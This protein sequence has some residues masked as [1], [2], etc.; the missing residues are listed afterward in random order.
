MNLGLIAFTVLSSPLFQ[1][2][3]AEVDSYLDTLGREQDR[4]PRRLERIALEALGTPY[5]DG[6]LGEG[7]EGTYDKD[8]LMDLSRADCVTFVEQSVAL[9]AAKSYQEAFDGL[10]HIRYK[11]GKIDFEMRNHFMISDWIANNPWCRDIS[12][13]LGVE[14]VTSTRVISKRDF[15]VRVKAPGLGEEEQDRTV[16]IQYVPSASG[17]EAAVKLPSPALI[18]FIGKVDWLFA[19]HCGLFIRDE[20][21]KGQLVHASSKAAMAVAMDLADYLTENETRYLGFTAYAL[22]KPKAR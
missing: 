2:S 9:A 11:G 7:P 3:P 4:F 1:M 10:Q 18:V 13:D 5:T 20:S 8:P 14:T 15:F 12:R 6:P 22:D 21:G 17:G 16:T 19:L